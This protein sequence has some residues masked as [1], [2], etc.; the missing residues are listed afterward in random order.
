M[1]LAFLCVQ[2][3]ELDD[4]ILRGSTARVRVQDP[5]IATPVNRRLIVP[6]R[7]APELK[8]CTPIEAT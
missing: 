1:T 6:N 3:T 8:S 4:P 2:D 7:N 5:L